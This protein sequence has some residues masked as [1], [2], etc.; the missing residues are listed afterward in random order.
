MSSDEDELPGEDL[1]RFAR[2][3]GLE[4]A[5]PG[6]YSALLSLNLLGGYL[7]EIQDP[8]K[9]VRE[10]ELLEAGQLGSQKAP[11]QNR[12]PPLKGLWHKHYMQDGMASLA[13]NVKKGLNRYKVPLFDKIVKEAHEAGEERFLEP[14]EIEAIIDDAV[15]GNRRRLAEK[16]AL[17]G[18]WLMFAK[19]EGQNYYLTIANH[20]TETHQKVRSQIEQICFIEFPFLEALLH[21]AENPEGSL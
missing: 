1:V 4:R 5:A 9:I 8:L 20:R 11:I 15:S 17:T 14:H 16:Q 13:Q 12:Y 21:E 19:H 7:A 18:E 6:R 10:I 2:R 3:I